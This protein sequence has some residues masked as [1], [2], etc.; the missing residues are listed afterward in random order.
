MM[1]YSGKTGISFL[2]AEDWLLFLLLK[3]INVIL[4]DNEIWCYLQGLNQTEPNILIYT[5]LS[6]VAQD[7]HTRPLNTLQDGS[8]QTSTLF[9]NN[10]MKNTRCSCYKEGTSR[11][12]RACRSPLGVKL[13]YCSPTLK[14]QDTCDFFLMSQVV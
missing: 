6:S 5:E 1:V 13:A 9:L 12:E 3:S 11:S 4:G 10:F 2:Y 14:K 8:N 7:H